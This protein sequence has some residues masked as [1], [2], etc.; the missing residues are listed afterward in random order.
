MLGNEAV[1]KQR[2]EANARSLMHF[3][4]HKIQERVDEG[5]VEE[6]VEGR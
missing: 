4:R 2:A 6:E 5:R 3:S 1:K